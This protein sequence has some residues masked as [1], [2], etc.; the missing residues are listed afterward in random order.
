MAEKNQDNSFSSWLSNSGILSGDAP[1]SS[2]T[3][4][5]NEELPIETPEQNDN[6]FSS[7]LDSSGLLLQQAAS[8]EEPPA[9][10][11]LG[12]YGYTETPE[13]YQYTG[14]GSTVASTPVEPLQTPPIGDVSIDPL[15]ADAMLDAPVGQTKFVVQDEKVTPSQPK[16]TSSSYLRN[17]LLLAIQYAKGQDK[18]RLIDLYVQSLADEAFYPNDSRPYREKFE[19]NKKT[20]REGT[21]SVSVQGIGEEV[22]EQAGIGDYGFES[23]YYVSPKEYVDQAFLLETKDL[24][25]LLKQEIREN[26]NIRYDISK[27]FKPEDLLRDASKSNDVI[28]NA[29]S[30][31]AGIVLA[32]VAIAGSLAYTTAG[33]T[34]FGVP[35]QTT[36][37]GEQISKEDN[38][39]KT[40]RLTSDLSNYRPSSSEEPFET[41]ANILAYFEDPSTLS[42]A[43]TVQSFEELSLRGQ[44]SDDLYEGSKYTAGELPSYIKGLRDNK[45]SIK[46]GIVKLLYGGKE[47]AFI[48]PEQEMQIKKRVE[49]AINLAFA[50]PGSD[51]FTDFDEKIQK[52]VIEPILNKYGK[53]VGESLSN[54]I[55]DA[56]EY[57]NFLES[58]KEEGRDPR[59]K[60][61]TGEQ[62]FGKNFSRMRSNWE[63]VTGGKEVSGDSFKR[64]SKDYYDKK[65]FDS[66]LNAAKAGA[67][68]N[69]WS[70]NG[71][72]A[73]AAATSISIFSNKNTPE[74]RNATE[75]YI[76]NLSEAI[77]LDV[78]VE[79][80]LDSVRIV[81]DQSEE[82]IERFTK[83]WTQHP[84]Y[85]AL[86]AALFT[87]IVGKTATL[88]TTSARG[89]RNALAAAAT[90]AAAGNEVK[91]FSLI[92]KEVAK[93]IKRIEAIKMIPEET[94]VTSADIHTSDAPVTAIKKDQTQAT[95]VYNEKEA[96]KLREQAKKVSSAEE[97][98]TLEKQAKAHEEYASVARKEYDEGYTTKDGMVLRFADE[99]S[100][101]TPPAT[102]SKEAKRISEW[103][104]KRDKSIPL[105]EV[106]G[107]KSGNNKT[108]VPVR[109]DTKNNKVLIDEGKVRETFENKAWS[110]GGVPGVTKMKENAFSTLNEWRNF[111][112]EKERN[113][114]LD[115]S[116]PKGKPLTPNQSNKVA[117]RNRKTQYD[118]ESEKALRNL[119][120]LYRS[121]PEQKA[122]DMA[123]YGKR[124]DELGKAYNFDPY[125]NA[126]FTANLLMEKGVTDPRIYSVL[127]TNARSDMPKTSAQILDFMSRA[128]R[129]SWE[130]SKTTRSKAIEE[131]L[132]DAPETIL[133]ETTKKSPAFVTDRQDSIVIAEYLASSGSSDV[134]AYAGLNIT[135]AE[136]EK[137]AARG[138]NV[139]DQKV[140]LSRKQ[141]SN[142]MEHVVDHDGTWVGFKNS[143]VVPSSAKFSNFYEYSSAGQPIIRTLG[144]GIFGNRPMRLFDR[145]KDSKVKSDKFYYTALGAFEFMNAPFAAVNI[146]NWYREGVAEAM[147]YH[148][149]TGKEDTRLGLLLQSLVKPSLEVGDSYRITREIAHQSN[150][151][152]REL[153]KVLDE[154]PEFSKDF[155]V[156]EEEIIEAFGRGAEQ[157]Y[158]NVTIPKSDLDKTFVN[159]HSSMDVPLLDGTVP[160]QL[161]GIEIDATQF[162]KSEIDKL[163]RMLDKLP[164]DPRFLKRKTELLEELDKRRFQLT[165][166]EKTYLPIEEVFEDTKYI[167]NKEQYEGVGD[168]R[169][170]PKIPV[171]EMTDYQKAV[172]AIAQNHIRPAQEKLFNLIA[173]LLTGQDSRRIL[174]EGS[175]APKK[176]VVK[177][178]ES[179]VGQKY[180]VHKDFSGDKLGAAKAEALMLELNNA[181]ARLSREAAEKELEALRKSGATE[182]EIRAAEEIVQSNE[183]VLLASG[184]TK[185]IVLNDDGLAARLQYGKDYIPP[186]TTA[187][188]ITF[189]PGSFLE[190]TIGYFSTYQTNEGI[191][192]VIKAN[193]EEMRLNNLTG[194]ELAEKQ[195]LLQRKLLYLVPDGKERLAK[196]GND[197]TKVWDEVMNMSDAESQRLF[198]RVISPEER[199]FHKNASA[200]SLTPRER[201]EA[202]ANYKFSIYKTYETIQQ[203]ID[204]N[205]TWNFLRNSGQLITDS[206]LKALKVSRPDVA[207]SFMP[208]GNVRPRTPSTISR[209]VFKPK[210]ASLN[211]SSPVVEAATAPMF[212]STM[213][214]FHISKP[215]GSFLSKQ[216]GLSLLSNEFMQQGL[217]LFKLAKIIDPVGGAYT[218]NAISSITF[219][220]YGAGP[221]ISKPK[222]ILQFMDDIKRME[223]GEQPLNPR[224]ESIVNAGIELSTRR[225]EFNIAAGHDAFSDLLYKYF[226][227]N[228]RI[229][230]E[231]D[232]LTA[233]SLGDIQ[234]I[235]SALNLEG[236]DDELNAFLRTMKTETDPRA[237]PSYTLSDPTG[238]EQLG[239]A[240]SKFRE[241]SFNRLLKGYSYVDEK[242]KGGYILQLMEEYN[243]SVRHAT[244]IA[245][246]VF[247]DYFDVSSFLNTFRYQLSGGVLGMPFVGYTAN[248]MNLYARMLTQNTKRSYLGSLLAR[249]NDTTL[250]AML[251]LEMT[252]QEYRS[253]FRDPTLLLF[254]YEGVDQ[255]KPN[256]Y[257]GQSLPLEGK[258][259]GVFTGSATSLVPSAIDL[260]QVARTTRPLGEGKEAD[261]W[262]ILEGFSK[263]IGGP[264]KSIMTSFNVY[265]TQKMRDQQNQAISKN[266]EKLALKYGEDSREYTRTVKLLRD[267]MRKESQTS[268]IG[269]LGDEIVKMVTPTFFT[270][271]VNLKGAVT[272]EG[273]S[274][275]L[276][277]PLLGFNI[278]PSSIR[279]LV[280]SSLIDTETASDLK[281]QTTAAINVAEIAKAQ[282]IDEK[283]YKEFIDVAAKARITSDKLRE[284]TKEDSGSLKVIA[285]RELDMIINN[286]FLEHIMGNLTEEEFILLME[287][288]NE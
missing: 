260:K 59:L 133:S 12:E 248:G 246:D 245:E 111:L 86:D 288:A 181:E 258:V 122:E 53:P 17:E 85:S 265:N 255:A 201:L 261:A 215:M 197:I 172:F 4:V 41:G 276:A 251:D 100:G 161:M 209:G 162:L 171:S 270:S 264:L 35:R 263:T 175:P 78:I 130:N 234:R 34:G 10:L 37:A 155:V 95:I 282:G 82:G 231:I 138:R 54:E 269:Q 280:T 112:I 187:P 148:Y 163:T 97:A 31:V 206:E 194:P 94:P 199:F 23:T 64:L 114:F 184:N 283:T 7:W 39:A 183:N 165:S 66:N 284:S 76:S 200:D 158:K 167:S 140:A 32:P 45:E 287:K 110:N 5:A 24:D 267:W 257:G 146:P 228:N 207:R 42:G 143:T 238:F 220:G 242:L 259:S 286:I 104:S 89:I 72:T 170:Y 166:E 117:Y 98:S 75:E 174:L 149:A 69:V 56:I 15:E 144:K 70:K 232:S 74:F 212:G 120:E 219:H 180:T 217:Q 129:F 268:G 128:K 8:P 25:N 11:D 153:A 225:V 241:G 106:S 233:D 50:R 55:S 164:D 224:V 93:E 9:P 123:T 81:F 119:N 281:A 169:F 43:S 21:R 61:L 109:A 277:R 125:E 38:A 79:D 173:Q 202:H 278:A 107:L 63:K 96:F 188:Q 103:E 118:I 139:R 273:S 243:L 208:V 252:A 244:S 77:S 275:P 237:V 51:V 192:R 285:A 83:K 134:G 1:T 160:S 124:L 26:L 223:K 240:L 131:I 105:E 52:E 137:F 176:I 227:K 58:K 28:V 147:R 145:A 193:L 91:L 44:R 254:P 46:K 80:M 141:S 222:Y 213:D 152:K 239:G 177:V 67:F 271:S 36:L 49:R 274:G 84:V 272:G 154:L 121:N 216:A 3:T 16:E 229:M 196:H 210:G 247:V 127:V 116:I 13:G 20:N 33:S 195:Q 214:G 2:T 18:Q 157:G 221:V 115:K 279:S 266:L 65:V 108:F 6:S 99:P 235:A 22:L 60:G 156:A 159:I 47:P 262:S 135:D 90:E 250:E 190:R 92:R 198:S 150:L 230:E 62:A 30:D 68:G 189:E 73:T 249:A 226:K 29:L 182:N 205:R 71:A 253:I 87:S 211:E 256:E 57:Q 142:Q 40:I 168:F 236:F 102:V 101:P 48:T 14:Y 132:K 126:Y 186:P 19:L 151:S 88:G 218:R 191:L 203:A 113:K 185:F 204:I 136:L 27:Q 178:T 179:S